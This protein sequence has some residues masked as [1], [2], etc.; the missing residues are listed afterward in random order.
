M[1]KKIIH[2]RKTNKGITLVFDYVNGVRGLLLKV[3]KI[4]G[5]KRKK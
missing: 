2:K 4:I 1:Q 5:K 3:R